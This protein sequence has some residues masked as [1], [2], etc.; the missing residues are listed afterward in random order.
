M[1]EWIHSLSLLFQ[2]LLH[3]LIDTVSSRYWILFPRKHQALWKVSTFSWH[4]PSSWSLISSSCP[5]LSLKNPSLSAEAECH[6][7][8][9][10]GG[11]PGTRSQSLSLPEL[12]RVPRDCEPPHWM[13]IISIIHLPS[14]IHTQTSD[15]LPEHVNRRPVSHY[16]K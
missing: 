8:D 13:W 2:S 12:N 1:N 4:S 16:F 6:C 7:H 11:S 3:W 15:T 14:I 9:L 5:L 10:C